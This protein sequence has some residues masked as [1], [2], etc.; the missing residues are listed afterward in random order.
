MSETVGPTTD[1]TA[2]IR[3]TTHGPYLITGLSTIGT[4]TPVRDS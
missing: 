2:K 3:V 4:R 1:R